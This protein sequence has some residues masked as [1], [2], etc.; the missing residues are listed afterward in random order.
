MNFITE[1]LDLFYAIKHLYK[2]IGGADMRDRKRM[3]RAE[4]VDLLSNLIGAVEDSNGNDYD[5]AIHIAISSIDA[6]DEVD[7][8]VNKTYWAFPV[9]LDY[10]LDRLTEIMKEVEDE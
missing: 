10:C 3:T 1:M 2:K 6:W 8:L 4:A 9:G 7:D 5:K